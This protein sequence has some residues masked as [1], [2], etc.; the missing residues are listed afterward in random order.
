MFGRKPRKPEKTAPVR[1]LPTLAKP[2]I[3]E[4]ITSQPAPPPRP[5]LDRNRMLLRV[6]AIVVAGQLLLPEHIKPFKLAGDAAAQF[7]GALFDEVNR[8]E[9]ELAQQAAIAQKMADLQAQYATWKGL[10][11]MSGTFDWQ[12]GAACMQ[13]ADSHFQNALK[14]IR[15]SEL[16]YR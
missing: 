7:H 2:Q 14:Q 10:C 16:I 12:I 5:P 6:A 13:A 1:K 15:R 11:S 4:K 3:L 8:K 9:L